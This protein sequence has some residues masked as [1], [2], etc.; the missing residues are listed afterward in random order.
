MKLL[1]QENRRKEYWILKTNWKLI[2]GFDSAEVS[3]LLQLNYRICLNIKH[4]MDMRVMITVASHHISIYRCLL[5]FL[6]AAEHLQ[7][8]KTTQHNLCAVQMWMGISN[9]LVKQ[10]FSVPDSRVVAWPTCW[11][12]VG[13]RGLLWGNLLVQQHFGWVIK[14]EIRLKV[15]NTIFWHFLVSK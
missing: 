10:D 14:T 13:Q 3:Y 12:S 7:A 9:V 8:V 4:S 6:Q 2:T 1:I 15:E 11:G 5:Y